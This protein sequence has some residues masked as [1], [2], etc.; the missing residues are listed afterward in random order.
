MP[1]YRALADLD[2]FDVSGVDGLE[3]PGQRLQDRALEGVDDSLFEH[4]S[5]VYQGDLPRG[6]GSVKLSNQPSPLGGELAHCEVWQ[7]RIAGAGENHVLQGLQ[8]AALES[9]VP[10]DL[11]FF[12]ALGADVQDLI[13]K[14]VALVQ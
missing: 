13:P 6:Y 5:R 7:N 8:V 4:A 9:D 11:V 10:S 3:F 2:D 14:A 12:L 1:S